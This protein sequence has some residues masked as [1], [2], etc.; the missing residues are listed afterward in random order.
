M[1]DGLLTFC[2]TT[3]YSPFNTRLELHNKTGLWINQRWPPNRGGSR[4][5]PLCA[6]LDSSVFERQELIKEYCPK[7]ENFDVVSKETQWP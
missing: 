3:E 1:Y 7:N 5:L 2:K 6:V 4:D